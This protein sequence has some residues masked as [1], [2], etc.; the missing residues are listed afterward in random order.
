MGRLAEAREPLERSL[1]MR[2]EMGELKNEAQSLLALAR[3]DR[4]EGSLE[5]ARVHLEQA[6]RVEGAVPRVFNTLGQV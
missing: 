3:L 2:R 6:A 5:E 4:R 1:A